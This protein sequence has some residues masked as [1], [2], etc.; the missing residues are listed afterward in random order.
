MSQKVGQGLY[1]MVWYN[2]YVGL[3]ILNRGSEFWNL[4]K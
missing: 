3:T 4:Q 2:T 1:L